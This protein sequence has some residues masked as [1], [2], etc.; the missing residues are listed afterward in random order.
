MTSRRGYNVIH[1]T[2]SGMT[3]WAVSDLNRGELEEFARLART[4]L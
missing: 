2:Q 4:G 3:C 1:W